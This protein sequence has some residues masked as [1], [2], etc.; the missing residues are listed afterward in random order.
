[1]KDDISHSEDPHGVDAETRVRLRLL[2]GAFAFMLAS[3]LTKWWRPDQTAIADLLALAGTLVVAFPLVT[4][5]ITAIRS[6]GFAATQYYMDQY[7]VLALAA[8]LATGRYLTGGVVAA[9][10]LFGQMIEERTT[11]GV[12]MALS[13]LRQLNRL[14]ARKRTSDGGEDSVEASALAIGDEIRI[15]PGEVVPADAEVLSGHALMDQSRVTGES[16]PAEVEP[17]R[18]IFAGTLNM[19]GVLTARVM[20]AGEETARIDPPSQ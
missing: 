17:G 18:R 3:V 12:E 1:M 19:N 11:L 13:K 2:F 10:L 4:G 16:V 5:L 14:L 8:C 20:G 9:V 6:T 7:V 15:R